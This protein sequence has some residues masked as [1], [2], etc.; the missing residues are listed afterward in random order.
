MVSVSHLHERD[1][2]FALLF[3]LDVRPA[4]RDGYDI[5]LRSV[6]NGLPN[7][8]GDLDRRRFAIM[9]RHLLGRAAQVL[10]DGVVAQVQLPCAAQ[11]KHAGQRHAARN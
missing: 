5:V 11:V 8:D 2:L 4:D 10:N 3:R 7:A 1:L 9:L 6:K